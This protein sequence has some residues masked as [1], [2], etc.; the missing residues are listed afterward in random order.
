MHGAD[1]LV[2]FDT[3]L[4][5]APHVRRCVEEVRSAGT[6]IVVTDD[7]LD[8]LPGVPWRLHLA[9]A[10]SF[11]TSSGASLVIASASAPCTTFCLDLERLDFLGLR[12]CEAL[13]SGTRTVRENGGVLRIEHPSVPVRRV[14]RRG[15]A[16]AR[17]V[18]VS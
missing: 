5:A 15:L 7:A 3:D 1:V 11:F 6:P 14:L 16:G 17:N 4:E 8:D 10:L 2:V 13:L 12:G 9:G 18:A